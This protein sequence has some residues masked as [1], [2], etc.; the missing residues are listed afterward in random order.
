MLVWMILRC[1]DDVRMQVHLDAV[2]GHLKV[3]DEV[4]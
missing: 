1:C 3:A 2:G 4:Q